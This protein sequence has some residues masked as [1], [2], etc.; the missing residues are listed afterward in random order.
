MVYM[1]MYTLI[2]LG[3]CA[4]ELAKL[5]SQL[6]S[7]DKELAD[8][9]DIDKVPLQNVTEK[10]KA[11]LDSCNSAFKK[12]AEEK[13]EHAQLQLQAANLTNLTDQGRSIF[14]IF[15]LQFFIFSIIYMYMYT[16]TGQPPLAKR[17]RLNGNRWYMYMYCT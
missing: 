14:V 5:R 9:K 1:Y 17:P 10:V 3:T 2:T 8:T 13:Q 12:L 7:W 11:C 16:Y 6:V 15:G 4:E